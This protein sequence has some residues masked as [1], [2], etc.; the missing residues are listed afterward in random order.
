M[1]VLQADRPRCSIW[2]KSPEECGFKD[3]GVCGTLGPRDKGVSKTGNEGLGEGQI[4]QRWK[5]E[6]QRE[7]ALHLSNLIGSPVSSEFQA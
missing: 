1:T 3:S 2:M 4:R 7:G 6:G 5:R